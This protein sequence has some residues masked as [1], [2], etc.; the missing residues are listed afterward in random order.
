MILKELK[1]NLHYDDVREDFLQPPHGHN[2]HKA[3]YLIKLK[4]TNKFCHEVQ[5]RCQC[6]LQILAVTWCQLY[7]QNK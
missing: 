4:S 3:R 2:S 1:Y 7:C 6:I 5:T